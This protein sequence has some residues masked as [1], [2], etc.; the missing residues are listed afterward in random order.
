MTEWI[1]SSSLL[2]VEWMEQ[3][4][5]SLLQFPMSVETNSAATALIGLSAY[6]RIRD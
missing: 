2:Q 3:N 4:L 5:P 6:N 1:H